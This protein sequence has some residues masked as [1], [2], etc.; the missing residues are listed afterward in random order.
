MLQTKARPRWHAVMITSVLN[1]QTTCSGS[2]A[3]LY[4]HAI[5]AVYSIYIIVIHN[6][7]FVS[8]KS[9]RDKDKSSARNE[10]NMSLFKPLVC[11]ASS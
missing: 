5:L 6:L 8:L 3:S 7:S 10:I 4:V 1:N 11:N 9:H 2:K